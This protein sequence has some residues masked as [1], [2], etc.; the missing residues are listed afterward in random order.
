MHTFFRKPQLSLS[1]PAQKFRH[2]AH[3]S[4][5][6]LLTQAYPAHAGSVLRLITDTGRGLAAGA[7]RAERQD[8]R[9][10]IPH[11][12]NR[13]VSGGPD[14]APGQAHQV[15][16]HHGQ[17]QGGFR[18]APGRRARVRAALPASNQSYSFD[19][20]YFAWLVLTTLLI[21]QHACRQKLTTGRCRGLTIQQMVVS[22]ASRHSTQCKHE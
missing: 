17:A 22:C 16:R 8:Y 2:L 21:C 19:M 11:P 12:N 9:H 10:G 15:C 1:A 3:H 7:P 13:C 4:S 6:V 5:C 18:G 14:S 20:S